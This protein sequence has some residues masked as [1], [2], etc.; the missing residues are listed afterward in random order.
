MA[1]GV[2]QSSN[3]TGS[4]SIVDV[5]MTWSGSQMQTFNQHNANEQLNKKDTV[6]RVTAL[7]A[8]DV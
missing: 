8:E 7:Y 6:Y 4:T 3:A 5:P 2:M 1:C